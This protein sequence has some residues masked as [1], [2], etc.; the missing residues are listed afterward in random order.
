M[1]LKEFNPCVR[2]CAEVNLSRPYEEALLAYDHR[3]F[4]VLS[5]GI[6]AEFEGKMPE[7]S[8]GGALILP[9]A[10]PYRLIPNECGKSK[11][12]IVN[13]DMVSDRADLPSR[14][15]VPIAEF[16]KENVYSNALIPPFDKPLVIGNAH[17]ERELLLKMC[18]EMKNTRFWHGE[19]ISGILK[20]VLARFARGQISDNR[21]CDG[22]IENVKEYINTHCT[23]NITNA[24]IACSFG[25]HP[26]Y[27]N[28]LFKRRTGMT[29]RE[30]LLGRRMEKARE[31]LLSSD[32]S[33]AE[34]AFACGFSSPSYFAEV[35]LKKN[36]V[37]PSLY[38]SAIR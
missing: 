21:S 19:I 30:Y 2:F 29:L 22:L 35:F 8:V 4:F 32:K 31:M 10:T 6:Y 33:I 27:L 15:P 37:N 7:I 14:A 9:P 12:I 3:L 24:Q 18:E 26:Y 36:G 28:T 20:T 25:Y 16:S 13:F 5:G 1:M 23:E 34:I 38:R 11:Y 17:L